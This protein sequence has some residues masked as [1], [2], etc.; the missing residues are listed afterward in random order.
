MPSAVL[1]FLCI[2]VPV[3]STCVL[4]CLCDMSGVFGLFLS[5]GVLQ[6]DGGLSESVGHRHQG[7]GSD[8]PA[9]AGARR[10]AAPEEGARGQG[11]QTGVHISHQGDTTSF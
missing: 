3:L 1:I 4:A 6:K 10:L 5:D 8:L 7:P 9:G 11:T 2:W